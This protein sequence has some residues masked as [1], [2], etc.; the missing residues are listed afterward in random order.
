M[1]KKGV[2]KAQLI[3]HVAEKVGVRKAVARMF[4]GE[5][6]ELAAK[7]VKKSG[8]FVIP[9]LGK[10]VLSKR[11]ARVGRH[12][13]TGEPL[14]IPAKTVLKFRIAKQMKDAVLPAKK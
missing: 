8:L 2:T 11:K 1:A 7:E 12:P 5:L 4:F 3:G 13:Q 6:C 14:Q 9:G 10:L